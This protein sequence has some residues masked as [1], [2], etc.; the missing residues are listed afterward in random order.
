MLWLKFYIVVSKEKLHWAELN[1]EEFY[2]NYCNREE[3]LNS[4][5][6]KQKGKMSS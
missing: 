4:T 2:E 1:E 3:R 6:L 5:P